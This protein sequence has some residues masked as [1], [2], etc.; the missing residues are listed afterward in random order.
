MSSPE[1]ELAPPDVPTAEAGSTPDPVEVDSR[2]SPSRVA[3]WLLGFLLLCLAVGAVS[4]VFWV[5]AVDLPTY[6]VGQDGVATTTERGLAEM[7]GSDAWYCAI[8]FCVSI[9]LGVVAWRWFHRLGWPTVP[10]AVAGSVIAALV[11]WYVGSQLGPGPF[12]ARMAA[13]RPGDVVPVQLTLQTKVSI[14]VWAFAV[15]IPVLLRASLGR[16]EEDLARREAASRELP[17]RS[18]LR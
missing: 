2:L 4:G 12:V 6:T 17:Y 7:F 8:G 13:A 1:N 9:G 5:Q 15:V 3:A 18:E 16:D 11:C 10:V 14:V